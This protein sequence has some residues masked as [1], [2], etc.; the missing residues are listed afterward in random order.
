MQEEKLRWEGEQWKNA[1]LVNR[2]VEKQHMSSPKT[3]FKDRKDLDS[4]KMRLL[5]TR[6]EKK[7]ASTPQGVTK[8]LPRKRPLRIL[9][10]EPRSQVDEWK[11]GRRNL[12]TL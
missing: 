11:N 3:P 12:L 7:K 2:L 10:Q 1:K 5:A 4:Q 8:P 6:E 9:R